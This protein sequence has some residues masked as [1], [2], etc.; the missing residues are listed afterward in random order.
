[1][2]VIILEEGEIGLV[3]ALAFCVRHQ[4]KTCCLLTIVGTMP[5]SKVKTGCL[6][7]YFVCS[8]CSGGETAWLGWTF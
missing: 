7:I 1:M 8:V 4:G 3:K 6:T 2:F 5:L